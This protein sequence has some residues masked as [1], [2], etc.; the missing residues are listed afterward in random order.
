M[1]DPQGLV[2]TLRRLAEQPTGRLRCCVAFS[3]GLDS[4]VLLHQ[5][6]QARANHPHE[7]TLRALH[8][9]HGLQPAALDFRRQVRRIARA[10]RVGLK[11]LEARVDTRRGRSIEEAARE[12]RY[13]ALQAALSPGE[14][15]L[16]A[17]HADDQ[18][19]TILQA[20]MR[21][22]GPAGLAG[23]ASA[24]PFGTGKLLRPL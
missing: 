1:T 21:G 16:T 9:D 6:V 2:V 3:G 7:L 17:Q 5:L 12:A 10:S 19:E 11:V 14:L 20:L 13:A 24:G 8:V 15:L 4:T 23:M 18:L 22:A